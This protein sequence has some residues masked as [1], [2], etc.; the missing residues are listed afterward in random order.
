MRNSALP[1]RP[2]ES[3]ADSLSRSANRRT[4]GTFSPWLDTVRHRVEP[5]VPWTPSNTCNLSPV[6]P[7]P[8]G[9]AGHV[10]SGVLCFVLLLSPRGQGPRIL[11][12][13]R[14]FRP[15]WPS[16]PVFVSPAGPPSLS[17]VPAPGL[18]LTSCVTVGKRLPCPN[19]RSL[20]CQMGV[21]SLA[22]EPLRKALDV[23]PRAWRL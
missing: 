23:C 10:M 17:V 15:R 1:A 5:T 20:I 13:T 8:W 19:L 22:P 18:E 9:L 4:V 14:K 2:N 7:G 12:G 6:T 16:A 3:S 11:S 21:K